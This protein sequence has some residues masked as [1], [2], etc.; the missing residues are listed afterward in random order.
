M[1][2]QKAK[3]YGAWVT[4]LCVL[5]YFYKRLRSRGVGVLLTSAAARSARSARHPVILIP[6]LGGTRL[7][8]K[9]DGKLK[10]CNWQGFFPHVTN[11]WRDEL[12][13]VY[14]PETKTF[15][16]KLP[17]RAST[18]YRTSHWRDGKFC[19]TP[20][21]GGLE[22][23]CN[24]LHENVTSSWQFQ[25]VVNLFVRQGFVPWSEQHHN[26]ANLFGAGFD[27][28]KIT[29]PGVWTFYCRSLKA[30]IEHVYAIQK[31]EVVFLT[32]SM[33]S[34]L[35]LT[36]FN[37]YLPLVEADPAEWKN[38]F[39]Q[40][41]VSVNGAFGGAG[42]S[43]RSIL[44]GDNNGMGYLCNTGCHDWY[45]PLIENAA[46]VLW[47]LPHPDVFTS[48]APMVTVQE[49]LQT[50]NCSQLL[51]LLESRV[52]NAAQAYRDTVKPLLT[53]AAPGVPFVCVTSIQRG[54]P[55]EVV[56]NSDQ[57][58]HTNVTMK[59][60]RV[61]YGQTLS[62]VEH[63]CGDGTVPYLSLMVPQTWLDNNHGRPVT[64][65]KF[66]QPDLGHTSILFHSKA[67]DILNSLC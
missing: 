50:Y 22:G 14:N 9:S 17:E 65:L 52:P 34:P 66:D 31:K 49:P 42:K 38:K 54:T 32:H 63:M 37:I 53:V 1:L 24:V 8:N 30:L 10:W 58:H 48:T 64:F 25:G 61:F 43:I 2:Q 56:Y 46:G 59:D 44:S 36:F 6:G 29:S 7:Y 67:L 26:K 39:V 11:A 45:Q 12:T 3:Q 4:L 27:F 60:E 55:L 16:D 21:F 15:D 5:I 40:R 13:V 28:R 19:A 35:L 41:W 62:C 20:D 18:P 47:M 57:F 51:T 33:G 23:V